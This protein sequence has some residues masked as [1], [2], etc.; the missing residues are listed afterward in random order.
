MLKYSVPANPQNFYVRTR[1]PL[2]HSY[3]C[4]SRH[5]L[6]SEAYGNTT[7]TR[8][9]QFS[10]LTSQEAKP[11]KRFWK[12]QRTIQYTL[13]T[14]YITAGLA[15]FK[16]LAG[17]PCQFWQLAFLGLLKL[18]LNSKI[19]KFD[20]PTW[21]DT[22][23]ICQLTDFLQSSGNFFCTVQYFHIKIQFSAPRSDMDSST[24]SKDHSDQ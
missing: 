1:T 24:G 15:G 23:V 13:Y 20:R 19:R 16:F 3:S 17:F 21:R 9:F 2:G 8:D 22:W 18:H 10:I 12:V 14:L 4:T 11:C 5:F 6:F 7:R